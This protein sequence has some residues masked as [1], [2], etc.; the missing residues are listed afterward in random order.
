MHRTLSDIYELLLARY[1]PQGWW[2]VGGNYFPKTKNV[3]EVMAGAVLTQNTSWSNAAKALENLRARGL[4]NPDSI[5]GLDMKELTPL[6]RSSGYYNQKADRLKR[7]AAFRLDMAGE[8]SAPP[9]R[10]ELLS[11]KGIGPETADSILL[12][13][14]GVPVFVVDAYTKRL[15]TRLGLLNGSERYKQIQDLFMRNLFRDPDLY[16][17]YHALIVRHGKETCRKAPLCRGCVLRK[18]CCFLIP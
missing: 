4:L 5:S 10:R 14:F 16:G 7:I 6:I 9:V 13:G 15:F 3:F 11:I 18:K 12:Y 1:G 17:E 2:P 8:G